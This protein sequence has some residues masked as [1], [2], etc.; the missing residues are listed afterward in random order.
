MSLYVP[1]SK[2]TRP[3]RAG[4]PEHRAQAGNLAGKRRARGAHRVQP[5]RPA[6]RPPAHSQSDQA[7][8]PAGDQ[9]PHQQGSRLP[10]KA[11]LLRLVTAILVEINEDWATTDRVYINMLDQN[12]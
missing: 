4:L 3:A 6:P 1:L 8:H 7:R 2:G 12:D 11:A 10:N 5:P 9:T